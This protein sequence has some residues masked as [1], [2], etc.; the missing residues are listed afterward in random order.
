[1]TSIILLNY[2]N[3]NDTIECLESLNNVEGIFNVVLV[4]NKSKDDDILS[5]EEYLR[6]SK[7]QYHIDFIKAN[8]NGGFAYGNNIGIKYAIDHYDSESFLLLNNDTVVESN[9]LSS[10]TKLLENEVV[11]ATP[12]VVFF[13]KPEIIWGEGG[14]FNEKLATGV[15]GNMLKH[16]EKANK[17][18]DCSF[19]SFCCVLLSRKAIDEV[20]LLSEDYFM[21]FE[22]ADY[23]KRVQIKGYKI[24]ITTETVVYHKV[25]AASG[26]LRSP[27]YLEW[28]TR[29]NR[30][31]IKKFYKSKKVYFRFRFKVLLKKI[32]F[33]L[34]FD[35]VK[36]KALCRGLK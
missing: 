19:A 24:A 22:D 29:S 18:N 28:C 35:F 2:N 21:Y 20:G 15:N 27:F 1:M 31:F 30:I 32:Y 5:I 25:S 6:D 7:L 23:C 33:I 16:I 8:T 9:L 26:G 3:H 12:R 13:D 10:L 34:H 14:Y 11:I 17:I 4:D 36:Y